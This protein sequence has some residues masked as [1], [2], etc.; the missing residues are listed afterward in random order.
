MAKPAGEQRNLGAVDQRRPEEFERIDQRRQAEEADHLERQAGDPEPR[1]Q[2]VEDEEKGQ[3]GGKAE[4][5]HDEAAPLDEGGER[6]ERIALSR[7]TAGLD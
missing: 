1:G 4:R 7:L 5:Q 6:A 2:R 3:P